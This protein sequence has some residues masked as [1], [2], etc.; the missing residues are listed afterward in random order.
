MSQNG[1]GS[2]PRPF[3]VPH[4]VYEENWERIFGNK[5][6]KT[7]MEQCLTNGDTRPPVLE[8]GWAPGDYTCRCRTCGEGFTG[9]KRAWCCADCAYETKPA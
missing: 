1:K 5:K 7:F 6:H 2:K 9:D 3:S 4:D 8:R